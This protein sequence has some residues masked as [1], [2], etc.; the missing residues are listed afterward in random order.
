[1]L[2]ELVRDLVEA[3][4]REVGKHDLGDRAQTGDG[5][6]ECTAHD[7]LL[8]DRGIADAARPE[9]VEETGSR[10]EHASGGADVLAE[11]ED[12]IVSLELLGERTGDALPERELRHANTSSKRSSGSGSLQATA[13]SVASR[14]TASVRSLSSAS[15]ALDATPAS[16]RSRSKRAVGSRASHSSSSPGGREAPASLCD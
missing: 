14:T 6:S 12:A 3:D 10:L 5:G 11:H 1:V 13:R 2:R 16:V 7:R 4:A 15:S 8:R 9:P